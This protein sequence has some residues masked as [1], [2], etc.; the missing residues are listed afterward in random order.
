MVFETIRT[1]CSG[2]GVDKDYIKLGERSLKANFAFN[3][4]LHSL[5]LPWSKIEAPCSLIDDL[6]F[7]IN[8]YTTQN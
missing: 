4:S 6:I 1:S 3:A 5:I 2:L 7:A 8:N